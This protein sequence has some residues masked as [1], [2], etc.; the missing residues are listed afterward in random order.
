MSSVITT[1][2]TLNYVSS[3]D[4]SSTSNANSNL[5]YQLLFHESVVTYGNIIMF[6]YM[7]QPKDDILFSPDNTTY[8]FLSVEVAS[9]TGILNQYVLSVPASEQT[10]DG[11]STKT[12][13]FRVYTGDKETNTVIVT[14]WSNA[15]N[16]CNPP[17]EPNFS[18]A[19]A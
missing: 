15:L 16:V 6:E 9:T 18:S 14:E 3:A 12:I 11:Q 7:I 2:P 8:G 1:S 5:T 17:H 19:F 13:Q 4:I 10:Y